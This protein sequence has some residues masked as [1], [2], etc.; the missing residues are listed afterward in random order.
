M[1][2]T[3]AESKALIERSVV[4]RVQRIL[5]QRWA[6]GGGGEGLKSPYSLSPTPCARKPVGGDD[7]L[8]ISAWGFFC[9]GIHLSD[10]EVSRATTGTYE[11]RG[12]QTARK[13]LAEGNLLASFNSVRSYWVSSSKPPEMSQD[14]AT[15]ISSV[16]ILYL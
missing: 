2:P 7:L 13:N 9:L 14:Q 15:Y 11:H 10:L 12:L 8:E 16:F 6:C 4:S 1:G 3:W 5:S